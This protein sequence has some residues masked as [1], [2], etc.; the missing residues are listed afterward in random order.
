MAVTSTGATWSLLDVDAI[1]FEL[2]GK[3][4]AM[5]F[6][7]SSLMHLFRTGTRPKAAQ[8]RDIRKTWGEAFRYS[9]PY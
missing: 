7:I 6:D 3:K 8:L 2:K 9:L 4:L 1:Y 5:P